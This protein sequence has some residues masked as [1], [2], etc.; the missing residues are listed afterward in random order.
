MRCDTNTF[1]SMLTHTLC[2]RLYEFRLLRDN[3]KCKSQD[4][5]RQ[6]KM[7]STNFTSNMKM[8][9]GY[10]LR[11]RKIIELACFCEL[12]QFDARWLKK[13]IIERE[14]TN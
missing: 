12:I 7:A 5:N 13:K 4:A 9:V 14:R 1:T 2:T 6:Y 11:Q 8:T 3:N 10:G